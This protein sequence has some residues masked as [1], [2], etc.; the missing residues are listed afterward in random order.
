MAACPMRICTAF[1]SEDSSKLVLTLK[2]F[3][4]NNSKNW[5]LSVG[6]A[7]VIVDTGKRMA[8]AS[9]NLKPELLEETIKITNDA[10]T[11]ENPTR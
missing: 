4:C 5:F 11:L 9:S 1:R 6:N 7:S 10:T 8:A 2:A 3:D